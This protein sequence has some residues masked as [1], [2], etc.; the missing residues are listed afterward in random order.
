MT[1]V[2]HKLYRLSPNQ[3]KALLFLA[4]SKNGIISSTT[5]STVL[6]KKGKA[7]GGVYSSLSRQIVN[8]QHIVIPWGK[9]PDGHGLRWKLNEKL[10]S[11]IKL[12]QVTSELLE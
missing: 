9:S 2:E 4:K 6:G 12:L 5:S 11:K 7:L 8:G 10:I 3:L 1:P